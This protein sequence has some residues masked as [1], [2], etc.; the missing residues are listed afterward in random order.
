MTSARSE[1]DI[2]PE[3]AGQHGYWGRSQ[4]PTPREQYTVAGQLGAT[5]NIADEP[6]AKAPARAD[7]SVKPASRGS[8]R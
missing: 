7:K 2:A 8:S 4:D 3:D 6:K 1:L 5:A